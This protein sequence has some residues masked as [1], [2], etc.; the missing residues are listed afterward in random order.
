MTPPLDLR[1][2]NPFVRLASL[3][4]GLPPGPSPKADGSPLNLGIGDP[5]TGM[6]GMGL[7]AM[8]QGAAG[9][10]TYPPFQ[11]HPS[12]IAAAGDWLTRIYDLPAGFLAEKGRVLPASGSREGIFFLTMAAATAKR[13]ALGGAQPLALLPDP[14]Y[15]VYAG[16]AL[17]VD[18]EPRYLK[19]D[20]AGGHL[21]DFSSLSEAELERAA[22]AFF[23]SP[24]NPQGAAASRER[25]AETLALARRHKILLLSDECYGDLY[26]GAA[27]ASA[28]SVAAEGG[29]LSGLVAAH[30]LSKRS[31][32]P[33][34]RC[35]F[36]SG[37]PQVL[38]AVEGLLRFGGA[39]V[40]L[41]VQEAAVALLGDEGHVEANRAFYRRNMELAERHFA[42][43][44]GWSAPDGGFFA[45]LDVTGSRQGNGEDAARDLW[46]EAGIRTLPGAYMS[47]SGLEGP[48][49]P[50]YPYL[51][52][53]L[54]DEAKLLDRALAR[55]VETLL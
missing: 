34:L 23:C 11:G 37:D 4:D 15:H 54:V 40:P 51:R 22:I 55:I 31:G 12:L 49:N 53:A 7:E 21:P 19:V 43:P 32:A 6:P 8:G 45:W 48:A 2:L 18:L 44:F 50:G 10:S 52:I 35:G 25:L 1:P 38:N 13:H 3:L 27:P 16:A 47:L 42:N 36:L 33:G 14:G 24:A 26:Y 20:A 30:S 46:T 28:L 17:A 41:P 5:R 9:W 39:G 29:D